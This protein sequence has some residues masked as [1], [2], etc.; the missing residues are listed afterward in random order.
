METSPARRWAL[1][2]L[3]ASSC[4]GAAN[5]EIT[6]ERGPG[7]P[8]LETVTVVVRDLTTDKPTVYGPV[9]LREQER[10]RVQA[11]VPPGHDF[12]VDV[13][14]CQDPEA[15]SGDLVVARGCTGVMELVENET[16]T[17]T[18]VLH[19]TRGDHDLEPTGDGRTPP[20]GCPPTGPHTRPPPS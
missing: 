2:A 16:R 4:G 20:A 13:F 14:G 6:L 10:F 19:A 12:Y 1:A 17:E 5:V 11:S 15:C 3:L 8:G 7:V 9:K 18:V